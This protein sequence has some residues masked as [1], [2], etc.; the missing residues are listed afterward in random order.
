MKKFF[1]TLSFII[2]GVNL[3]SQEVT[4]I[5]QTIKF[6]GTTFLI[7]ETNP[8]EKPESDL[9][10]KLF[11]ESLQ[12]YQKKSDDTLK[13]SKVTEVFKILYRNGW[14]MY[15]DSEDERRMKLRRT[16]CF[17]SIALIT[18]DDRKYTFIEYAKFTLAEKVG[19]HIEF[20][21]GQYLA[22]LFI[23]IIFKY[24]DNEIS[25]NDLK[26]IREFINLHKINLTL[27]VVTKALNLLDDFDQI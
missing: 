19:T 21:E 1:T 26:V 17:A 9:I 13:T 16:A 27:D 25:N 20:R 7:S 23:E 10:N 24:G 6:I 15:S 3:Y 5:E 8:T 2:V 22:L 12:E 4:L 18:N 14:A 11:E